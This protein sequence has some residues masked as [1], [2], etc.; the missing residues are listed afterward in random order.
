MFP[1]YLVPTVP[2]TGTHHQKRFIFPSFPS[3][4]K[5]KWILIVQGGFD[6][7]L[8]VCIYPAFFTLTPSPPLLTNSLSPCI[9]N[10]QQLTVQYII[11]YSYIDGLF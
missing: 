7:V 6:L 8:Q 9:P 2:S 3:L 5:K 10:I 4:K 1:P 11:L